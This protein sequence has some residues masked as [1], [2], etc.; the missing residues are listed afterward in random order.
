M[1]RKSLFSGLL[2]SLFALCCA[3][4]SVSAQAIVRPRVVSPVASQPRTNTLNSAVT[5][6]TAS[7]TYVVQKQPS[8][9]A[10]VSQP[11]VRRTAF[12][13]ETFPQAVAAQPS[14]APRTIIQAAPVADVQPTNEIRLNDFQQK[15]FAEMQQRIGIRYVYGTQGPYTYDCS[16]LIWTVFREAGFDFGRSSAV[17]Y[18]NQ[19]LPVQGDERFKFGTLVFFNNLG[20]VG[21]VVDDKGFYHASSSKG[22]TYSKFDDYWAKRIVGFRRVPLPA[23]LLQ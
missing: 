9:A 22:V 17:T 3:N 13:T 1:N 18:W 2:L 21:I 4:V 10:A 16:G 20:H 6:N 5:Q 8:T 19:F 11:L 7:Q 14:A 12:V 23:Q 15:L